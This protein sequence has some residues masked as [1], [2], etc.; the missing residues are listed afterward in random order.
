MR[1]LTA[2]FIL[3][4]VFVPLAFSAMTVLAIRPWIL[5]RG[6][7]ERLLNDE[8]LLDIAMTEELPKQMNQ[9]V[10]T[11]VEELPVAA[12]RSAL[13][14]VL[15]PDYVR[16]QSMNIVNDVFDYIDGRKTK[17]EVVLDI[18]PIKTALQGEGGSR[19]A[20][21]LAEALP[22]CAAS[23]ESIAPDGHLTRCI[24]AG[25][26]VET[27]AQQIASALPAVLE[28]MPDQI[29]LGDEWYIR[30]NWYD[31]IPGGSVRMALDFGLISMIGLA[32]MTG[33]VGAF[34]GGD[35]LRG[36]LQWL[37]STLFAPASLCLAI[38]LALVT[39]LVLNPIH[40]DL[41]ARWDSVQYSEAYRESAVNLVISVIQ[42]I[43]NGFVITGAVACFI[44]LCLLV[45]SLAT[46]AKGQENPR[47]V[48]VP[49]QNP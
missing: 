45:W 16:T 43:G 10:F 24:A 30:M 35:T 4:V 8:H 28:T 1:K 48:Q 12:L 23:Q 9:E 11:P 46:P 26:S 49:V 32:V 47:M 42:Q 7:Y 15:T 37:S 40:A 20:M 27:A 38:G 25:E 31:W 21:S 39:P 6:F 18:A 44:A 19:F 13:H 22:N 29:V 2:L 34:I 14:D 5:D 41:V 17:F 3:I 33:V 36:R